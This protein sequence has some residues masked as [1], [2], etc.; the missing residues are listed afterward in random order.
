MSDVARWACVAALTVGGLVAGTTIGVAI[1]DA[2]PK[3]N[4]LGD[5]GTGL[6][7]V[8]FGAIIGLVGG[9]LLAARSCRAGV[10]AGESD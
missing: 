7:V 3:N 4:D 10:D 5:L 2:L 6:A 9:V 1:A 8:A